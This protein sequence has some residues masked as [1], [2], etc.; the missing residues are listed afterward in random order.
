MKYLKF[1]VLFVVLGTI[2]YFD[3][4]IHIHLCF[5]GSFFSVCSGAVTVN[6]VPKVEVLKG[7]MAKLPCS[8]TGA[9]SGNTIV[10]WSIV[11]DEDLN[12]YLYVADIYLS[13]CL[14]LRFF[15]ILFQEDQG[16]RKRVGFRPEGGTETIDEG[17][18]LTGRITIGKDFSLTISPTQASD[19]LTFYCQV[20]AGPSGTAD[21]ATMLKVFRKLTAINCYFF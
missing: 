18:V 8:F 1:W 7:D 14:T 5:F 13:F 3:F 16:T 21:A 17:T 11:S 20:N 2:Q 4:G 19:E 9:S 10:E 15:S 6:V 12:V